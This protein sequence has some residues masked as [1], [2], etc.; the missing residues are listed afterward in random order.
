MS[1]QPPKKKK[2][3]LK[4]TDAD[5]PCL[6]KHSDGTTSGCGK[7]K[8]RLLGFKPR[9]AG[10]AQHKTER[11]RRY[12]QQGCADCAEKVNSNIR[13]PYCIECDK[14]RPK[15]KRE[16]KKAAD[17]TPTPEPVAAAPTPEPTPEPVAAEPLIEPV[18]E[19]Q[20]DPSPDSVEV[21]PEPAPKRKAKRPQSLAEARAL[22][23]ELDGEA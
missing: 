15:K 18:V 14:T 8:N 6:V 4:G 7:T 9:W 17:P 22:F 16:K 11:G 10:C 12:F 13:Q 23:A 3:R 1:K 20:P 2:T 5:K 19:A 21:T